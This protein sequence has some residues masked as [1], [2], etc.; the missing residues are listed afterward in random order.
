VIAIDGP[1]GVGKS[2][3]GTR[4][5]EWLGYLFLD[6]GVLYRAA[7][8]AA[9]QRGIPVGDEAELRDLAATLN[10][11]IRLPVPSERHDQ[12]QYTVLL[13]GQDVTW[14]LRQ[15]QVEAVVSE[16][17]ARPSVRAALL[18]H[19]R[20]IAAA[21]RIVM[22]GRDIGTIVLPNADLKIYL[23]APLEERARRRY[24]ERIARGE[25]PS[26]AQVEQEVAHRD[27]LDSH[28]ATAP[29]RPAADAVILNTADLDA[30][31]V[32]DRVIRLVM[33]E[34]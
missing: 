21:G 33:S 17:A 26:F 6:S 24:K 11:E 28:R 4:L 23:D 27:D 25:H 31:E 29:L 34:K 10:I 30:D 8:L 1:A 9:L 14:Q 32:L 12:R 19:Q 16:V 18:P 3:V 5:A 7:A 15:P 2:T 20:A 22:V 13:D